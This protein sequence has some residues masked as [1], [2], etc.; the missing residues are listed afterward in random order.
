MH[1]ALAKT[2]AYLTLPTFFTINTI[3]T[4]LI[5][6]VFVKILNVVIRGTQF[7]ML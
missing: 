3:R 1:L 6:A 5:L 7:H 4:K 2:N